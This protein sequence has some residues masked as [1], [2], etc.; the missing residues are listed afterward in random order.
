MVTGG[1]GLYGYAVSEA[2]C[3]IGA[4]VVVAS[5]SDDAFKEKC[6]GL[7]KDYPIY[8]YKLDLTSEESIG[9]LVGAVNDDHGRIDILVNNA[10]TPFGRSL[11]D[12]SA[13][14]WKKALEGNVLSLLLL[15]QKAAAGMAERG[16]GAI[17]NIS[18]IFGTVAPDYELYREAGMSP[19]P[20]LYSLVKGGVNMFTRSLASYLAPAGVRVNCISPGGI[21]DETDTEL[22]RTAYTRKTPLGRWAEPEDIKGAVMYL[23]SDAS[24]YV[25]GANVVVDGGYTIR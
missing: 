3:E 4:T 13:E 5:R 23:A 17:L 22:Y 11:E 9:S 1:A 10:V 2:L 15:C 6:A 8:H 14:E 7:A 18:S 19:N 12:T 25:T 16:G 21:A 20:I 24:R